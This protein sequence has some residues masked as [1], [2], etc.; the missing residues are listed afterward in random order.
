MRSLD[1]S[2]KNPN[3]VEEFE[4]RTPKEIVSEIEKLNFNAAKYLKVIK[5]LT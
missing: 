4:K 3:H 2:V 5:D 1:L